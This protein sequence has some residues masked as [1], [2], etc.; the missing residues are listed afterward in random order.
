MGEHAGRVV[1]FYTVSHRATAA[2]PLAQLADWL[3]LH[4]TSA[5]T[6]STPLPPPAAVLC[7]P[8][9]AASHPLV[10]LSFP[11]HYHGVISILFP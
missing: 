11:P 3:V 5:Q 4:T 10:R 8:A 2:G 6:H 9:A 1:P 7:I